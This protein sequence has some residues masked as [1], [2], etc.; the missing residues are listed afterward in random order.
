MSKAIS[1]RFGTKSLVLTTYVSMIQLSI[2]K[3]VDMS[4]ST[5]LYGIGRF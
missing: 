4:K 5:E 1:E 2:R 3:V